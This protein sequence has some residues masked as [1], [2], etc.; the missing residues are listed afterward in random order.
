MREFV[1]DPY[2]LT[3][4]RNLMNPAKPIMSGVVQNQDAY[5]KGKV[6]QRFFYD[7]LPGIL[8]RVMD[9]YADLT[10][11]RYDLVQGYRLEDADFAIVGMGLVDTAMATVDWLRSHWAGASAPS[12]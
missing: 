11:R 9:R 6:G 5:M 12:T 10:G 1:G 2:A 8:E 4:L 7:R 3:R